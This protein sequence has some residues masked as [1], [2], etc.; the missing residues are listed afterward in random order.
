MDRGKSSNYCLTLELTLL[1]TE[2]GQTAYEA[3]KENSYYELARYLESRG[4]HVPDDEN[5]SKVDG[6][7]ERRT[8]LDVDSAIAEI[9]GKDPKSLVMQDHGDACSSETF[10]ITA[11]VGKERKYYFVK[12][13]PNRE[14]F[15]GGR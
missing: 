1:E 3:A 6:M 4:G 7:D 5:E 10:K 11:V 8:G 12:L 2:D 9:I 13:G 15:K 14:M